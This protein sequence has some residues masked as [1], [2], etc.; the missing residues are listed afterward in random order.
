[1]VLKYTSNL[2]G[3]ME[4]VKIEEGMGFKNYPGKP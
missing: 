4:T 3:Q 2:P 1:M